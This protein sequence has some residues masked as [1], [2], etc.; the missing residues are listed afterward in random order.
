MSGLLAMELRA[1]DRGQSRVELGVFVR[2]LD[3]GFSYE[4]WQSGYRFQEITRHQARLIRD[5]GK[6]VSHG[7]TF[8]D[9][10]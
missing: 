6:Q 7:Y 1:V 2:K 5:E 3:A 9:L 8:G 4:Y 10:L